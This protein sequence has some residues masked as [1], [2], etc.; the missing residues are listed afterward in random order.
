[1]CTYNCG[2]YGTIHDP[3]VVTECSRLSDGSM[4]RWNEI[5]AARENKDQKNLVPT[6]QD[7]KNNWKYL[8]EPTI[9]LKTDCGCDFCSVAPCPLCADPRTKE[10]KL[11][12]K[13]EN[14]KT[15]I[16]KL[17]LKLKK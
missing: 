4:T 12:Q 7:I 10:Q 13:L 1:M 11:V 14:A 9:N 3:S 15:E 6:Q 5:V 17:N 16:K 8:F 2:K